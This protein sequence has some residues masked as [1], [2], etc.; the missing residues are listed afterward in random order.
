MEPTPRAFHEP[1]SQDV[2]NSFLG[3]RDHVITALQTKQLHFREAEPL[4]QRHTASEEKQ[5]SPQTFIKCL[6]CA[7]P[8]CSAHPSLHSALEEVCDCE[9]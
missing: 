3:N 5:T 6:L 9:P 1:P 2:P 8:K 7:C 4:V